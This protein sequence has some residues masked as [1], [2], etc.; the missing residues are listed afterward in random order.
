MKKK[1]LEAVAED[2]IGKYGTNLARIAV[3]F[4]NKRASLFLNEYLARITDR[5]IWS[6]AYI[7]IS[8]LFRQNSNLVCADQ[9]KLICDLHKVFTKVTGIDESLDH[10]YG[11][12]QLLL[13]D[14][15]NIDKN[16]ADADKVF[17]N[18]RDIHEL[19]DVSYLN[20]EQKAL[21]GKFFANF[22]D[23]H[24]SIL[25]QRFL[26]L[27]SNFSKIYHEFNNHLETQGLAYEGALYRK[28]VDDETVSFPYETYLFVGFNVLQEVEL[29]LFKRLKAEGKAKFY[30]DFDSYYKNDEQQEAGQ[31]V[32]QHLSLFN[33]EL[34][35]YDE[36]GG[37]RSEEELYRQFETPKD[38]TYLSTQTNDIQ[39]RYV[40]QWLRENRR[41]ADG[42]N[43][44][45]VLCDEKLLPSVIHNLPAEVDKVNITTGYPLANSP[46]N[47]FVNILISLQTHGLD[48]SGTKYRLRNVLKVLRHPY[49]RFIS[50]NTQDII[51]DLAEHK[52]FY[53]TREYLS[54][55]EGLALLFKDL[56]ASSN[57]FSLNHQPSTIN[58]P[59]STLLPPPS[60][61]LAWLTDVLRFMGSRIEESEDALFEE[62]LFKTYTLLNRFRE[63]TDAG[64]L[65]TDVPTL[66]RLIAQA[67]N[68]TSIPFHGEPAC[69]VQI[70]G[71]LETRNLDFD[72]VL[73][74][75]CNEG[76]MPKGVSDASFIPYSIRKAYGLTTIDNNVA[77]YA[78][79]F[80]RLLQRTSDATLTYNAATEEGKTGEMSRFMLQ[81]MVESPHKIRKAALQT[82]QNIAPRKRKEV[83]KDETVMGILNDMKS[84]SPT[85]INRYIRCQLLFY[86]NNV[87]G[88]KE[89]DATDDD[90]VDSRVFGNIFH[91]AARRL[92]ER[93][94]T[95]DNIVTKAA[96]TDLLKHK[97]VIEMAVDEAFREEL[98][99]MKD[100]RQKPEYNGLQLINREVLVSYIVQ[101][102]KTDARLGDFRVL[103]LEKEV[104]SKLRIENEKL[105]MVNGQ[106]SVGGTIDRLDMVNP[107]SS[108]VNGQWII[109]VVDYKTGHQPTQQ[110]ASIEEIF[111]GDKLQEKHTDYYLQT[112]LYSM[113]VRHDSELNPQQLPVSPALLF[114]QHASANDYNPVLSIGNEKITDVEPYYK[115]FK[116]RLT[117]VINEIFNPEIPFSPTTVTTRC[118]NCPYKRLCIS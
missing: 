25:K 82:K 88:I 67:F 97:E 19:D 40:S 60:S 66:Q 92:Y 115:E 113:I 81:M 56:K 14:F 28:V 27:W 17:A 10:F 53:P 75:S 111:T 114:I 51:N 9:L 12:G 62:S 1:F 21:L 8:D 80:Y 74:L 90:S 16:L 39:A 29:K 49:A 112:L 103:G 44:A 57:P 79:Y 47:S 72:H 22:S 65:E 32:R 96:I 73:I 55:D 105:K 77:I 52:L 78:Y 24:D 108:M 43:T 37:A 91:L 61:L 68:S 45:I 50:D 41:Y 23:D 18:L 98:F 83:V 3:V 117:T 69:G 109:R 59:P 85:A 104:D 6:P 42:R 26:K 33:N 71:V 89:P 87:A 102:L 100:S 15:D 84:L 58:R 31:Y 101:L 76:N 106:L 54:Q 20:N 13:S 11:W 35:F 7:T 95:A 107:Q 30:W 116:E 2:I 63:L 93:I 34:E 118:T 46:F 64:D 99:K 48:K 70:M 36:E 86:Y 38:I 94:K 4:P 110:V 5:P